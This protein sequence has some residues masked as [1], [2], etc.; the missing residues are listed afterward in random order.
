MKMYQVWHDR[1]WPQ[2]RINEMMAGWPPSR[3]PD[4][5]VHV[6]NVKANGLQHAVE[7]T[8]DQGNILDGTAIPWE[9]NRGVE[10]LSPF[11]RDTDKG[12]VVVDPQGRPFRVERNSFKELLVEQSKASALFEELRADEAAGKREDAHWY[13]KDTYQKILDSKTLAAA[14]KEETKGIE[15]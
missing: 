4:H 12:D 1:G 10:S 14:E 13:G 2:S 9:K 3:F 6:A 15:R 8:T 7:L 5:Y 11:Q